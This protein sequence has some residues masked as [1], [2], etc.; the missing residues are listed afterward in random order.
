MREGLTLIY[1]RSYEAFTLRQLADRVG[2]R[3]GSLY[4]Y[5]QSKQDLLA[6][7]MIDHLHDVLDAVGR[8][9]V[10]NESPIQKLIAF[11]SFHLTYHM[12]KQQEVTINRSEL[13]SLDK[14]NLR[15][16]L[17]LRKQYEQI[18]VDILEEAMDAHL[19]RPRDARV[20]AYAILAMLTGIC[21]WY[22]PKGPMTKEQLVELHLDLILRGLAPVMTIAP[23]SLPAVPR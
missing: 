11:V 8:A 21:A 19:I 2:V 18:L 15:R 5:I 4:N 12:D 7:L 10:E 16:V 23:P 9:I 6:R 1:E 3:A 22:D 14:K 13:R 20:T 17:A